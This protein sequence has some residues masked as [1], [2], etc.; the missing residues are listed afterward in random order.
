MTDDELAMHLDR[1]ILA[2]EYSAE[3]WSNQVTRQ[4]NSQLA[5]TIESLAENAHV[6]LQS[7][8]HARKMFSQ[9]L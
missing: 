9:R 4:A 2:A 7:L 6:M 5:T 1:E 3:F 8:K